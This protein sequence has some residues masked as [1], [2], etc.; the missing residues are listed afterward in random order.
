MLTVTTTVSNDTLIAHLRQ[1]G[2]TVSGPPTPADADAWR[3][4]RQIPFS[5]PRA[6]LILDFYEAQGYGQVTDYDTLVAVVGGHRGGLG[7]VIANI[8]ASARRVGLGSLWTRRT[9]LG[10]REYTKNLDI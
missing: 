8:E 3:A 1:A 9:H 4:L 7:A 6:P 10:T 5:D 2:Y